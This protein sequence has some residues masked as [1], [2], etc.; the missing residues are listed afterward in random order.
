MNSMKVQSGAT[1]L[2]LFL[3]HAVELETE[4]AD[5]YDELADSMEAHNN[6]EVATLFHDLARYS[7]MHRDEIRETAHKHG[8]VP[9][10]APWDFQWG[11]ANESP[12]AA[13]FEDAHYLMT[14]YH[15][16]SMALHCEAQ[17]RDY[18]ASVAAETADPAVAA[19]A[20]EYAA[21]E[22]EHMELVKQW[23]DR[24]PEPE[25]GWDED[26]DP[27]NYNE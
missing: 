3:A 24:F 13:A 23:L 27:P 4:A 11:G 22:A 7:R 18:Y 6:V 21:E 20:R 25:P 14:P 26:L 12:E 2:G 17:A 8:P 19:L 9:N 1:N 15:A 10:V 5:R 16:L